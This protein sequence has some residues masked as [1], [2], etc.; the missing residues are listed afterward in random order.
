MAEF[1]ARSAASGFVVVVSS[2]RALLEQWAFVLES[3]N[4]A[5]VRL[6]KPDLALELANRLPAEPHRGIF[7]TTVLDIRRGPVR[8]AL[9]SLPLALA[10]LDAGPR[11]DSST[12]PAVLDIVEQA[13]QTIVVDQ[14]PGQGLPTWLHHPT[15]VELTLD[16]AITM[17]GDRHPDPETY[18]VSL[19]PAE[20]SLFEQAARLL[21]KRNSTRSRPAVHSALM[22]LISTHGTSH[23]DMN[24]IDMA[25]NLVDSLEALGPD[26]RLEAMTETVLQRHRSGPVIVVTGPLRAEVEYVRDHLAAHGVRTEQLT[27]HEPRKGKA[28]AGGDRPPS[29]IVATRNG[30]DADE[31]LLHDATLVYF[32]RPQ[33]NSDRVWLLSALHTGA[34]RAAIIPIDGPLATAGD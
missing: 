15:L 33:S 18:P 3:R 31:S 27:L 1:A 17:S 28:V 29:V 16:E 9:K 4:A 21:D 5:P 8:I 24:D 20:R 7:L 10:V 22:R 6:L 11:P 30:L 26:P 19:S 34:A 2:R 25:W 12:T 14:E 13:R 32:T 23:G